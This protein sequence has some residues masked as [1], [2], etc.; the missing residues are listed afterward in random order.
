MYHDAHSHLLRRKFSKIRRSRANV[1]VV[2]ASLLSTFPLCVTF[3]LLWRHLSCLRFHST[4]L[5]SPLSYIFIYHTRTSV[6]SPRR[7]FLTTVTS[8]IIAVIIIYH[9]RSARNDR[10]LHFLLAVICAFLFLDCICSVSVFDRSTQMR[11]TAKV[12]TANQA[13]SRTLKQEHHRIQVSAD[14][15]THQPSHPARPKPH[16]YVTIPPRFLLRLRHLRAPV[17]EIRP[18][19]EYGVRSTIGA[20]PQRAVPEAAIEVA[21][22]NTDDL[23]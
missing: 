3:L 5:S 19:S 16:R 12:I 13:T 23:S 9:H 17:S 18:L 8:T 14:P 20:S 1:V 21:S 7:I 2:V 10:M 15:Y 6:H 4:L 11:P 22:Q